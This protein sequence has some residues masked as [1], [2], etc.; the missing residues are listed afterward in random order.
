[1]TNDL[2]K[3]LRDRGRVGGMCRFPEFQFAAYLPSY[4]TDIAQSARALS[5]TIRA[6]MMLCTQ[7]RLPLNNHSTYIEL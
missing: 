1:M 5:R 2:S 3:I 4:F 7:N 6:Y